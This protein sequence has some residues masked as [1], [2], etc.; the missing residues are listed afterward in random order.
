MDCP[1]CPGTLE[2]KTY[3]RKITVDRPVTVKYS[4][5]RLRQPRCSSG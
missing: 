3:G 4:D 2:K 1:K 5:R